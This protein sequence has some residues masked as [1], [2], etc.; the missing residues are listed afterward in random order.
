VPEFWYAYVSVGVHLPHHEIL[1]G[2]IPFFTLI[3]D[4]ETNECLNNN[5]GCWQNKE[6]N[7]TA[8]KVLAFQTYAQS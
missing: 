6:A 4:M 3:L 8:C 2:L 1:T 5:G 7:V